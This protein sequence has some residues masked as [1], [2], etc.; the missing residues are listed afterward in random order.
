M[1]KFLRVSITNIII[2]QV[3]EFTSRQPTQHSVLFIHVTAQSEAPIP[4]VPIELHGAYRTYY[5]SFGFNQLT[6]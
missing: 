4:T 1:F 5:L 6:F 3:S 2:Q